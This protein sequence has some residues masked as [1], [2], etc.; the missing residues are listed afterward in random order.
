MKIKLTTLLIVLVI[1]VGGGFGAYFLLKGKDI[2]II[3]TTKN[4]SKINIEDSK[5]KIAK[6][7]EEKSELE[8]TIE[9][10]ENENSDLKKKVDEL[11]KKTEDNNSSINSSSSKKSYSVEDVS[12]IIKN[13]LKDTQYI[14]DVRITKLQI[15]S[16]E[17]ILSGYEDKEYRDFLEASID[18]DNF[19]YGTISYDIKYTDEWKHEKSLEGFDMVRDPSGMLYEIDEEDEEGWVQ[20]YPTYFEIKNGKNVQLNTGWGISEN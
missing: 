16:R 14:S 17:E 15:Y 20:D 5:E 18:W 7:E 2:G 6:L 10:V 13:Y 1:L 12:K 9:E 11:E 8:K 19:I 3:K 4:D